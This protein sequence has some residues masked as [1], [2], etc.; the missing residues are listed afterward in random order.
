MIDRIWNSGE[1]LWKKFGFYVTFLG[2]VGCM[3]GIVVIVAQMCNSNPP[4]RPTD[5][6]SKYL[7]LLLAAIA[8]MLFFFQWLSV[9]FKDCEPDQPN[10]PVVPYDI[11]G[12]GPY[13][14]PAY[15]AK[16]VHIDLP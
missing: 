6:N 8:G 14:R 9:Q 13:D 7:T 12:D 2:M 10:E 4:L 15:Q 3:G 5:W 11:G 1:K 16:G